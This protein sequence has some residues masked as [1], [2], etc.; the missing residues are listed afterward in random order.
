M[1][2]LEVNEER[3]LPFIS[4][5]EEKLHQAVLRTNGSC[6]FC[7]FYHGSVSSPIKYKRKHL[8]LSKHHLFVQRAHLIYA[9]DIALTTILGVLYQRHLGHNELKWIY[10]QAWMESQD[11]RENFLEFPLLSSGVRPPQWQPQHI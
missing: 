6:Y 9:V 5:A 11:G 3:I 4:L 10:G 2:P 1:D 7:A 8:D